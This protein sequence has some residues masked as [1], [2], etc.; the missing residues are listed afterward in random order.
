MFST[1]KRTVPLAMV[2]AA[3]IVASPATAVEY[4]THYK[5]KRITIV[6]PYGPG[7][8]YDK[9]G[10]TFSRHLGRFIPGE[11]TVIV[12]H[13][14][15][16][17]GAKAMNY[18][19][20]VMQKRGYNMV[21]PL[22]NVVINQLLRPEKMR[23]QSDKF[24][25][26]G[27]SNQTNNVMVVRTDSGVTDIK[28]WKG[29]KLIGATSGK[30]STGYIVPRLVMVTLGLEGKMVTGYKGSSRSIMA[31]EQGEAQM[32]SFNWLAWSSKVPH[33]FEVDWSKGAEPFAR[34]ILQVGHFRDPALPGVPMLSDLVD[35]KYQDVVAFLGGL[36]VLGRGLALPPG[37]PRALVPGLR[38]SYKTMNGDAKFAAELKKRRLR[39]MFTDGATLQK[40]VVRSMRA[41][42][43]AVI[44]QLRTLIFGGSS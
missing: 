13:M 7:G 9:Y 31:I 23:Y 42:T 41:T 11:P 27:S 21:V 4:G 35:D 18:T 28:S 2:A 19:Y 15:G 14:P 40:T 12:Q 6:I 33:W 16:A 43:P 38:A 17:G 32:A 5:N 44:K 10:Q 36:G 29:K 34:A 37:V 30:G 8:T 39:L 3:G 22:D 25:W 26:I 24:T 1:I 20:N